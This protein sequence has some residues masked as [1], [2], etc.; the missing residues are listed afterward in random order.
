MKFRKIALPIDI[1][2][3]QLVFMGGLL[4]YGVLA[5]DL[6][7]LK[8]QIVLTFLSGIL[9]QLFWVKILKLKSSS[10]LSALISSLSIVLLLRSDNIWIHPLAAFIAINS[11]FFIQNKRQHFYNPS[12]L[13]I[14]IVLFLGASWLSPGQWSS[15]VS[16]AV[17]MVACGCFIVRR[18]HRIDISWLFL[19][20]YLSGLLVRNIYLGYE[21]AIFFH[22]ALNGS[23]L[24]FAFF[25]IS[26]P[27]TSP[28][29]FLGK[30]IF[31]F[32]VAISTLIFQYY[33]YMQ[34]GLIYSLIFWSS[35]IPLLNKVF[36]A[37]AFEW[38]NRK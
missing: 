13:G 31:T 23:L 33:F 35:F 32:F 36:Q 3:I 15:S 29:H 30:A 1:R 22:S 20:F 18:V 9:T 2:Y 4:S 8:T 6:S 12:A 10:L 11:K 28:N 5:F 25:M 37:N 17:W 14:F 7:I 34:N 21:M 26:D 38:N 16:L 27:R 24:L 19:F